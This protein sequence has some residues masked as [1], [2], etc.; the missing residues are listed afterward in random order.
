MIREYRASARDHLQ[1][2]IPQAILRLRKLIKAESDPSSPLWIGHTKTGQYVPEGMKLYQP[3]DL[4]LRELGIEAVKPDQV[5]TVMLTRAAKGNSDGCHVPTDG[6]D[7]EVEVEDEVI[8]AERQERREGS[9][10]KAGDHWFE[11]LPGNETQREASN[12]LEE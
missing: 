3:T 4:A 9:L 11:I 1:T 10:I 7:G 6:D 2:S 5:A 8:P 12:I